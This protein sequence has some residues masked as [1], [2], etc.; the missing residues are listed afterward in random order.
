LRLIIFLLCVAALLGLIAL[1]FDVN[2]W[3]M[4]GITAL[5]LL[6]VAAVAELGV[7]I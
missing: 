5:V 3:A 4:A 1:V 6:C 2:F 7:V